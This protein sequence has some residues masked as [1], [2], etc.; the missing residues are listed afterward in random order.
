MGANM[1][2]GGTTS[3]EATKSNIAA[4]AA[5]EA[6]ATAAVAA[7]A[8]MEAAQ[9]QQQRKMQ[10]ALQ[11]PA[12]TPHAPPAA[13]GREFPGSACPS[14]EA[15]GP[16]AAAAAAAVAPAPMPAVAAGPHY[17]PVIKPA[18][19]GLS[20]VPMAAP[21]APVVPPLWTKTPQ[22][23]SSSN[24]SSSSA[25]VSTNPAVH[26]VP[27]PQFPPAAA[28]SVKPAAPAA[29][30]SPTA[31]A[32]AAAA[33][34]TA[35]PAA[36]AAVA[37]R[38]V[39]LGSCTPRSPRRQ[40]PLAQ[41]LLRMVAA[42]RKGM[43]SKCHRMPSVAGSSSG[44]GSSCQTPTR[45]PRVLTA[46]A[47]ASLPRSSL[48][49]T[50]V[51]AR[52]A[53]VLK[54]KGWVSKHSSFRLLTPWLVFR[55]ALGSAV[56]ASSLF[57]TQAFR[58]SLG[59]PDEA[60]AGPGK[61]A[62]GRPRLFSNPGLSMAAGS[63]AKQLQKGASNVGKALN[64]GVTQ[65]SEALKKLLRSSSGMSLMSLKGGSCYFAT[66]EVNADAA[67]EETAGTAA[68]AISAADHKHAHQMLT[69]P[70]GATQL[71]TVPEGDDGE[72]EG[73]GGA[74]GGRLGDRLCSANGRERLTA[75]KM[76]KAPP[77]MSRSAY[78]QVRRGMGVFGFTVWCYWHC[79][80]LCRMG[81][82]HRGPEYAFDT[83]H[84]LQPVSSECR[85]TFG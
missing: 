34:P 72:G 16:T 15:T 56:K 18:A 39:K 82:C 7:A 76:P 63:A 13:V 11:S 31:P 36:A 78:L 30:A 33:G 26:Q 58:A 2:T 74:A 17:A 43:T 51:A 84:E 73:P 29:A 3:S 54:P 68:P 12:S 42:G 85:Y 41:K 24:S 83:V 49:L 27:M 77:M 10:A 19:P 40:Q 22:A 70:E 61:A 8:A 62:A 20:G 6:A 1:H 66:G 32:A 47:A 46:S 60:A 52:K 59:G 67:D 48:G 64:A 69:G 14:V 45:G 28:A 44:G 80:C 38:A 81:R 57:Y 53:N 75:G 9:R 4:A 50:P 25:M 65:G 5:T 23:H 71:G 79:C 55:P 21:V 35:A 37:R